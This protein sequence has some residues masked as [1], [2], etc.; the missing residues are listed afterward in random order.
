VDPVSSVSESIQA[1]LLALAWLAMLA[2]LGSGPAWLLGRHLGS[3]L[4][5]APVLGLAIGSAVLTSASFAMTMGT[6]AYALLLP[7]MVISLVAASIAAVRERPK[8]DLGE[9]LAPSLISLGALLLA[10][11]PALFKGSLGPFTWVLRDGW[12]HVQ[13]AYR[14][15]DH[16]VRGPVAGDTFL[17]D[18]VGGSAWLSLKDTARIGVTAL[19]SAGTALLGRPPDETLLPVLAAI[20]ALLSCVVWLVTRLAGG[21]RP[22][23]GLA[24]AIIPMLALTMLPDAAL[25]NITAIVLIPMVV[26]MAIRMATHQDWRAAAVAGI[27]AGGL[28]PSYPELVP[29]TVAVLLIAGLAGISAML[30]SDRAGLARRARM[31]ALQV[32]AGVG[33]V[34]ALAPHGAWRLLDY[35]QGVQESAP[36]FVD[37]GL[38]A[39]T[40]GAWMFGLRHIYELEFGQPAPLGEFGDAAALWLPAALAVCLLVGVLHRRRVARTALVVIP[41]VVALVMGL[42]VFKTGAADGDCQYCLNK[43]LTAALPFLAVGLGLGLDALSRLASRRSLAAAAGALGIAVMALGVAGMAFT[44]ERVNRDLGQ[45]AAFLPSEA[46]RLMQSPS[47]IPAGA[48][49]YLEGVEDTGDAVYYFPALY[50]LVKDVPRTRPYFDIDWQ[51]P[52]GL[53]VLQHPTYFQKIGSTEQYAN[54][55]YEWVLTTFSGLKND[56]QRVRSVGRYA[57]ERRSAFDVIVARSNRIIGGRDPR[58]A[59]PARPSFDRSFELWVSSPRPVKGHLVATASASLK[60]PPA[61]SIGDRQVEPFWN[62]NRRFCVDLALVRGFTVVHLAPPDFAEHGIE[63]ASVAAGPGG[64]RSLPGVWGFALPSARFVRGGSHF[65]PMWFRGEGA[66]WLRDRASFAVGVPGIT[67]PP[68]RVSFLSIGFVD[69]REVVARIR[70]RVVARVR[71]GT[72]ADKPDIVEIPVPVG[73][74]VVRVDLATTPGEYPAARVNPED[75]RQLA[76]LASPLRVTSTV[77]R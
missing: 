23:A 10:L 18:L 1:I 29:F 27:S 44:T 15:E 24:A 56:R 43:M 33:V 20:F 65:E 28:L 63:L 58:P 12:W 7:M 76:I 35:I 53:Y 16:T 59:E 50:Q 3:R 75:P 6:A 52:T 60:A 34:I 77:R 25:G 73:R 21:S 13:S 30:F 54:P 19:Y 17:T 45:M 8:R 64:C 48:S 74:G 36:G 14:L 71:V 68:V 47:P 39:D 49:V 42:Y 9:T 62:S 26:A 67:R 32:A 61:F 51:R 57:V 41:V 72:N 11:V 46:R 66:R 31:L 37:R 40:F 55:S 5:L 2:A 69:P 4:V 70:G 38:H 22:A